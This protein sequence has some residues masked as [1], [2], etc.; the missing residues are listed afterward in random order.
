MIEQLVS[1][2]KAEVGGKIASDIKLPAGTVDKVFSVIGD[3]TKKEVVGQMAGGNLSNVMNLF[4][5]K[6]NNKAANAIQSNISAEVISNLTS[7]LGLSPQ[8]AKSIAAAAIPALV[9]L[10]TQK[11][12]TTPDNDASPLSEIF[13]TLGKGGM[14]G[15]LAQGML[16]GLFKKK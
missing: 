15:N 16:G 14:L 2:V 4:S 9:N 10:I 3:A 8:V 1:K 11:N 13:G 12:N 5:D 7:K 6:P